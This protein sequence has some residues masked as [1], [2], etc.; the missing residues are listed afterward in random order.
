MSQD[1]LM[2]NFPNS[3][4]DLPIR[5]RTFYVRVLSELTEAK[6]PFLVGGAYALECYTGVWRDTK[7]LDIFVRPNEA[8]KVLQYFNKAGFKV[9]LTFPHWLGK[10]FGGND[11]VDVIFSSGNGI[12]TVDQ[13]WF[14]YAK[15]GNILGARRK[16]C[17]AE[18][19]IWSKAFVMERERFDGADV[20][21][22]ILS[23]AKYLDWER[24]LNRFGPHW[25]ILFSHLILFGFVYPGRRNLIPAWLMGKLTRRLLAERKK[26]PT[27]N[28]AVQGTLLSRAQYLID[29]RRWGYHD[30]RLKPKG[31]MSA[32]DIAI[33][34]A[35]IEDEKQSHPHQV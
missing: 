10:I 21:H 6:I 32:K 8:Q 25:E 13:E 12:A 24:L 22:L 34:T 16:I 31:R 27:A 23:R 2:L 1:N 17:P 3:R 15:T 29:L 9:E 14:R 4:T 11:F 28:H 35:A 20:A 5:T 26:S 7:D 30:A 18:E 19:M 33:W